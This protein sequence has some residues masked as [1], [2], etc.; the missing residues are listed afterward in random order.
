MEES[1]HAQA[2]GRCSIDRSRSLHAVTG[3]SRDEV[4][5]EVDVKHLADY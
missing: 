1:E 5:N 4:N 2:R 3:A